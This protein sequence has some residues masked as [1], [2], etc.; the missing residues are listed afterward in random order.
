M[1]K[2]FSYKVNLKHFAILNHLEYQKIRKFYKSDLSHNH[3]KK[4]VFYEQSHKKHNQ[5]PKYRQVKN[6]FIFLILF[7][8]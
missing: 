4:E 5:Q 1:E 7:L 2:Y 6:I 8:S 3:P